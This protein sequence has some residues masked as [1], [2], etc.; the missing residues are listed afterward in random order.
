MSVRLPNPMLSAYSG[1]DVRNIGG[2]TT[3]ALSPGHTALTIT[4]GDLVPGHRVRVRI[5]VTPRL[6]SVA[7]CV[8]RA[9]DTAL[10]FMPSGIYH[11]SETVTV[12]ASLEIE[13]TGIRTGSIS[14]F[15]LSDETQ[16]PAH[17]T[18]R[19]AL[20]LQA[21]V[22]PLG[23]NGLRWNTA[24]WNR[25]S[26]SH[27]TTPSNVLVWNT[28]AWDTRVWHNPASASASWQEIIAPITEISVTRGVQASGPSLTAQVG[29][30]TARAVNAL[31]PRATGMRHGTPV[32]LIHW[33]TRTVI[34]TGVITD[35][36]VT[37]HKPGGPIQ[38]EVEFTAADNVAR[39]SAITRYGAKSDTAD[40]Y[41]SWLDRL[42]RLVRSAPS[43]VY[44]LDSR[45][46]N[47]MVCPTVWETSLAKH[48]DG[49]VASVAGAWSVT[50]TNEVSIRV[51]RPSVSQMRF[52]DATETDIRRGI[53]SYTAIAAEWRSSDAIAH[54]TVTN[55]SA[56]R[57]ESGN[58]RAVDTEI[59]VSDPTASDIW[60]GS[61]IKLDA[62]LADGV[63]TLA[64]RYLAAADAEP[65]PGQ[66]TLAVAHDFG[67]AERGALMERAAQ[68]DPIT[69]VTVES[70]GDAVPIL[71]TQI[72]HKIT[73][74]TWVSRLDL[75]P[76]PTNGEPA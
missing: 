34:Y 49:L 62:T 19:D 50:R 16:L 64:R 55:H 76:N 21:Y 30:L 54:V 31:N 3:F 28:S 71:V 42:D 35:L 40:G 9:G 33:P 46:V 24:R 66:I 26:W 72:N 5:S 25:E 10:S 12:G 2:V 7:K 22:P 68:L 75:I 1:A 37:P 32:K 67:P 58:W 57:D 29:T 52:T 51:S 11:F 13:I 63:E 56:E 44:N 65:T 36:T 17:P 53:W 48:L 47:P 8:I 60:A 59:T 23:Q 41:E 38:Y 70:R 4:V 14:T 61:N 43:L 45:D 20:S 69:A 6:S 73:P 74:T 27:A 18:P 15:T 39:L